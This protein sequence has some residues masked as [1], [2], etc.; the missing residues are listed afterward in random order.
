MKKKDI[1]LLIGFFVLIAHTMVIA[2]DVN[3]VLNDPN[4]NNKP[5]EILKLAFDVSRYL[6]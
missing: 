5:G 6:R 2:N 3:A 4:K 1:A